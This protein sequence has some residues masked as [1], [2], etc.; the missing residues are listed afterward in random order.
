MR[1]QQ[2]I[3]HLWC[4]YHITYESAWYGV[5]FG[6]GSVVRQAFRSGRA[7]AAPLTTHRARRG[8]RVGASQIPRAQRPSN[9]VEARGTA[10]QSL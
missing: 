7:T 3:L 5:A 9:A 8:R 6:V 4:A 2:A 1:V 10:S